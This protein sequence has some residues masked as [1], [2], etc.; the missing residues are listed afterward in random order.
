MNVLYIFGIIDVPLSSKY[1]T[2][3]WGAVSC[4]LLEWCMALK[5]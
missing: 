2:V 3:F 5:T 4:R 1:L